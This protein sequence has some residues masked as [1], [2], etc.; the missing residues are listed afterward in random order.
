MAES[1]EIREAVKKACGMGIITNSHV[2]QRILNYVCEFE[3]E[4]RFRFETQPDGKVKII[5]VVNI[6]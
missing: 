3:K 6:G 1:I 5:E 2:A 4:K